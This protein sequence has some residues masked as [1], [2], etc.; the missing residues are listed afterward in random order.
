MAKR[1]TTLGKIGM[2][3]SCKFKKG[4]KVVHLDT[5]IPGEIYL[6]A[7]GKAEKKWYISMV[8]EHDNEYIGKEECFKKI[9]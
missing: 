1:Q 3:S 2:R 8:D 6:V 7:W 9:K 4:D 5:E